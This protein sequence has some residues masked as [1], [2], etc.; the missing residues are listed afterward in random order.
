MPV[1]SAPTQKMY[2]LPVTAMNCRIRR[3]AAS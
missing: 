2:G 3:R 1:M